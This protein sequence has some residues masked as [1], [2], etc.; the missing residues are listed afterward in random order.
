MD[1]DVILYVGLL[2]IQAGLFLFPQQILV[3]VHLT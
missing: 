3:I 2:I 1:L